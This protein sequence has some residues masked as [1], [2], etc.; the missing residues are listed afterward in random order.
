MM[1]FK[2]EPGRPAAEEASHVY[3]GE[4][5]RGETFRQKDWGTYHILNLVLRAF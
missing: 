5:V 4:R 3:E 2:R 1:F